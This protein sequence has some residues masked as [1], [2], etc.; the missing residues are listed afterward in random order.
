MHPINQYYIWSWIY[1]YAI[2][3][4]NPLGVPSCSD[5]DGFQLVSRRRGRCKSLG[6][7]E[8]R[9][10]LPER[11]E[12]YSGPSSEEL[13]KRIELCRCVHNKVVNYIWSRRVGL[14]QQKGNAREIY[15]AS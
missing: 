1:S 15:T 8:D 13:Q 5:A 3:L 14:A 2:R 6:R 11:S 7:K 12:D 4:A 10:P 9:A